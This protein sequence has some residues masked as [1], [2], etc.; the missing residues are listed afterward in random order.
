MRAYII[1]VLMILGL[2][3]C[4]HKSQISGTRNIAA[5][6]QPAY[7]QPPPADTTAPEPVKGI[8]NLHEAMARAVRTNYD[9]KLRLMEN[10]L[11]DSRLN[12]P[13]Y[14]TLPE[15]VRSAGYG[16]KTG[17][18]RGQSND[19]AYDNITMWNILDYGLSFAVY[20]QNN[21]KITETVKNKVLQNII[22][23]VRYA[24]YRAASAQGLLAQANELSK[25]V[26]MILDQSNTSYGLNSQ[27]SMNLHE[28]K[29][30]LI[31]NV[32]HIWEFT[33]KMTSAKTELA[34]LMNVPPGTR[35]QISEP[36]WN[37]PDSAHFK[38][39]MTDM[40]MEYLTMANR[41]E[42][43]ETGFKN[44]AGVYETRKAILKIHP[45]VNFD[46][47]YDA[48]NKNFVYDKNWWDAGLQISKTLFDL[49]SGT[50]ASYSPAGAEY[51][52]G[53]ALNMA[54]TTQLHLARQQY[55]M[56]KEMFNLSA[57]LQNSGN[58]PFKPVRNVASLKNETD[59]L[60]SKMRFHQAYSDLE[61]AADRLFSSFGITR[62]PPD[63]NS[64]SVSSLTI[65]L[66]RSLDRRERHLSQVNVDQV[67]ADQNN[68]N[69]N[70]ISQ[71]NINQTKSLPEPQKE[72]TSYKSA[73]AQANKPG[74]SSDLKKPSSQPVKKTSA[75]NR[76]KSKNA[77]VVNA[78]AAA[79]KGQKPVREIS[80]FRD[81]VN[82][83]FEPSAKS[84]I[85]G[86]GLI[87]ERYKLLGWSP[88][89]WLRI[90]MSDG[91]FGWIPTKYAKAV[92][93]EEKIPGAEKTQP[94]KPKPEKIK[95]E[96]IVKPKPKPA[97]KLPKKIIATTTRANV[98]TGPGL[99]FKII[100][101]TV[102]GSKF[103][104]KGTSGEW[105]EIRTKRGSKGW[106]HD[107]TVKVLPRD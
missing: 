37:V 2:C 58:K 73:Q 19:P 11:A 30:K 48:G 31:E 62:L 33:Q 16:N 56:A 20:A 14:N 51:S 35:F 75:P 84:G 12:P 45:G 43:K 59:D 55:V 29:R 44:N 105:F 21:E 88:K 47:G 79:K 5:Q 42:I 60:I 107:S 49:M 46:S 70:N 54:I 103:N 64:G 68:I 24:Y 32:R 69:Q 95:L 81:V 7:Q 89:G 78:S 98:R 50:Q 34:I 86:Q 80:V 100:Y 82:I 41:S 92:E 90:E 57:I 23:E 36:N 101:I 10:T 61:L 8:I 1:T 96:K 66:K 17:A 94:E 18:N 85:K 97:P 106:L 65:A 74:N 87:G 22:N 93:I 27:Q 77:V 67:K 83:H 28:N 102:K 63:I 91:S 9:S 38:Q 25:Q 4:L 40:D 15:I 76:F 53:L 52:K 26:R 6:P 104:V 71:T 13:L 3:G 72:E 99:N 39:S